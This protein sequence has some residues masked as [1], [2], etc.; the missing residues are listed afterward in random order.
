V[1]TATAA[2]PTTEGSYLPALDLELLVPHPHNRK[3]HGSLDDLVADVRKRGV[4]EPVLVRPISTKAGDLYQIVAGERRWRASKLAERT[5]IPAI[6]RVLSDL[7]VA[8][9]QLAENVH[10]EDLHPLD[11]AEHFDR[12]ISTFKYSVEDLAQRVSKSAEYVY[13]RLKLLHLCAAA[14]EVFLDGHLGL[15]NALLLARIPEQARQLQALKDL[16]PRP[17]EDWPGP[18]EA[19]RKI[20]QYHWRRLDDAPFDTKDAELDRN[21]GA[22]AGCPWRTG[23]QGDLFGEPIGDKNLC[24]KVSC[25]EGKVTA[26][27]K[28]AA[29]AAAERG[30]PVLGERQAKSVFPYASDSAGHDSRYR[31]LDEPVDPYDYGGERTWRKVLGKDVPPPSAICPAPSGKMI[32]VYSREDL[33]AAARRKGVKLERGPAGSSPRSGPTPAERRAGFEAKVNSAL[34]ND[35]LA[36]IVGRAPTAT[37]EQVRALWPILAAAAI[38]NVWHDARKR[39]QARRDLRKDGKVGDVDTALR[40]LLKTLTPGD[41]RGLALELFAAQAMSSGWGRESK[42]RDRCHEI[43]EA[44]GVKIDQLR[45]AARKRLEARSAKGTKP[46]AGTKSRKGKK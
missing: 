4:L 38:D 37:D 23:N 39:V 22:C 6:V 36:A 42:G 12:M 8:E 20:L 28:R 24:T 2:A 15:Q 19:K 30:I 13:Q 18:K 40:N 25:F 16:Q 34:A 46:K 10:R 14:R 45:A 29:A 26:Q 7:E 1:T 11:E 33:A 21:A 31:L 9:I 43:A 41:A 3:H 17:S 44:L 5:A 27:H 35:V 32:E